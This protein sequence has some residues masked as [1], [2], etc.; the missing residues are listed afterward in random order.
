MTKSKLFSTLLIAGALL[1]ASCSRTIDV[2]EE[3]RSANEAAFRSFADQ[4]DFQRVTVPGISG[5]GFVYMK[6]TQAGNPDVPVAYTDE[7]QLFRDLYLTTDWN[8]DGL[9][10]R[11]LRQTLGANAVTAEA[12]GS[13]NLGLQIAVQ[14]LHEGA[15]AEVVVPWYFN[16]NA[17]PGERTE[18]YNSLFYRIRLAKVI[19]PAAN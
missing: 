1:G 17:T 4:P 12:V 19:K 10:A 8:R 16:N 18:A 2:N 7:V 11:R 13:L 5:T 9:R 15:E 14:N 3:R 6:V